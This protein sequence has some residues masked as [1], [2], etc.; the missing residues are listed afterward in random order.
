MIGLIS[1][2][3]GNINAFTNIYKSLNIPFKIVNDIEELENVK[4]LI[5]PG[6]GAFDDAMNKFNDS[7]LRT[8]IEKMVLKNKIPILGVCVGMQMLGNA[9]DEGTKEGLGWVD[10]EVKL[11]DTSN[12]PYQ[13]KLPHMGWN[14]ISLVNENEPIFNQIKTRDRFYFL[15]SYYF[16]CNDDRQAIAQSNYGFNFSCALRK[17]NIYGVQFHPEKSLKN[18]IKL[19]HNFANL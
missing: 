15:H 9:S 11:F 6:V 16:K 17:D 7:G 8:P 12:I 19:L 18:G 1:Y 3:L 2:G 5:L 4:K 14:S 10:G 13:T